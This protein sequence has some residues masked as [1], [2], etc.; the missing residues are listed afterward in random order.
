M[1]TLIC[2]ALIIR[3][4]AKAAMMEMA[5]ALKKIKR[6]EVIYCCEMLRVLD[7]QWQWVL[8]YDFDSIAE[9]SLLPERYKLLSEVTNDF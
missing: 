4:Q 7:N 2:D 8:A 9:K 6:T 5:T 1:K 3:D